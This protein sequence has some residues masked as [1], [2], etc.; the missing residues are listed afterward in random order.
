M[1]QASSAESL[2]NTRPDYEYAAAEVASSLSK[3]KHTV[4]KLDEHSIFQMEAAKTALEEY[5]YED[6][7]A[8]DAAPLGAQPSSGLVYQNEVHA[9]GSPVSLLSQVC[10]IEFASLVTALPS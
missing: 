10:I 3:N 9:P 4:L 1:L 6:F 7:T 5:E 8:G 2:D